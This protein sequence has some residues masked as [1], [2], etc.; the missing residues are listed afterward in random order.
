MRLSRLFI[1]P[2]RELPANG[3]VAGLQLLVR[4]GFFRSLGAGNFTSLLRAQGS[5]QEMTATRR[6]KINP[7]WLK[8]QRY[9]LP[10]G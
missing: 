2:L 9:T 8:N 3:K 1:Q 6:E 5:I 10:Y 7:D 4:A